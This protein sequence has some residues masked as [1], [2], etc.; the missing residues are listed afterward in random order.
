MY[1]KQLTLQGYKS[2]ASRTEFLFSKGITAV[3]G[4]NG[5]GKSNIADAIRWALGEQ[6]LRVLRGKSTH[7]MIFAGGRRRAQSGM[8]EAS[9]TLDNTD[10]GLPIDFTEVTI[11]RRAYRSGENEYLVNGSRV[12]LR[13]VTQLLAESGLSQRAYAVI[14]QGLVDAALSLRPQERR[15][16][17]EEAAGTAFYRSQLE[18]AVRRLDETQRN[19]ER[20]RDIV[21]EITPRLH[22]LERE[23]E[24]VEE[25][26]RLTTHLRRLQRTW[27][28]YQWGRLQADL[29]HAVERADALQASLRARQEHLV[30]LE[31]RISQ[32]R[33]QESELR[34]SLRDWH[35]QSSDLHS[36]AE[37]VQRELAVAEERSRLLQTRHEELAG[38]LERLRDQEQAQEAHVAQVQAEA[39]RLK[40]DLAERKSRLVELEQRWAALEARAR[41][42]AQRQAEVEDQLRARQAEM[43]TLNRMLVEVRA[44]ATHLTGEQVL[45]E[46]RVRQLASQEDELV[47][48]LVSLDEQQQRQAEK[49]AQAERQVDQQRRELAASQQRFRDLE[50]QW[51]TARAEAQRPPPERARLEN[52]ILARRAHSDSLNQ[53]LVEARAKEA[54]LA[55]QLE[56]LEQMQAGADA[57]S[58]G[59]QALLSA[60]L[61]GVHGPL[62]TLMTVPPEWERA[63]EAALGRDLQAVVVDH[64][65]LVEK[66]R[67]VVDAV[68]GR[69]VL[70][71]LDHLR[72]PPPLPVGVLRAADVVSFVDAAR[73]AVEALLGGTVL[74][75][76][77]ETARS[78]LPDLPPGSQGVTVQGTVLR[79]NGAL[80][81]GQVEL[82]GVLKGERARRELPARLEAARRHRQEIERQ[83][84]AEAANIA[85]LEAELRALDRRLAEA[86][87]DAANRE[88]EAMAKARAELAGAE[89]AT[90]NLEAALQREA[91]LL[92][93]LQA[94]A[95]SLQQQAGELKAERTSL[96]ARLGE[97][98][99]RER[100]AEA[101]QLEMTQQ[102]TAVP[103]HAAHV[104][105][106][107]E[108]QPP[109]AA[110]TRLRSIESREHR[111]EAQQR[112]AA[113]TAAELE[114]T[115]AEL[116]QE[117]AQ[118]REMA[119]Q[120]ER[121]TLAT[122]RTEVAVAEEAL[123]NWQA[124]LQRETGLLDR[125]R[126]QVS[127]RAYRVKELEVEREALLSKVKDLHAQAS[128]MEGQLSRL[129]ERIQPAEEE[130][131]RVRADLEALADQVRQAQARVRDTELR[132]GQAKLEAE[133]RQDKLRL[134]AQQI[135]EELGLV[136]LELT[137][138]VTAQTP[139]PLRPLVSVLPVVEDLPQGLEEE[140]HRL[141]TRLHRLRGVNP[142]APAEY[143]ETKERHQFLVEQS[144]DL[145]KA[146]AQLRQTATELD[147]LMKAAFQET[148]DAVAAEFSRIFTVLF[149]GGRARLELTD[150]DDM[151]NTGVDIVAQPP[152]KRAQRLALLSSGERALTATALL[153]SLLRVSPTPFC[154][155]DEVDAM[156][157]EANVGRFRGLLEE[158]AQQTQFVVITH[159]RVTVEAADTIYGVSMGADGVSQVVSLKLD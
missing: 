124:A 145:E 121:E 3:V 34:T 102:E 150:P 74:C 53:A 40:A 26:R 126:A 9:L 155:L 139:L 115:L 94:Q 82:D 62:S 135:E 48:R 98:R 100:H 99:A 107:D 92:E 73:P 88:R 127:A 137:D 57:C 7:D 17:F 46:E 61:E 93:Q 75:D 29:S 4:P 76:D 157:D 151:M 63:I 134:L 113:R 122:A 54:Q 38:E 1:L 16:L 156:L 85:T 149:N 42:T 21:N 154:V 10:G 24:R 18:D 119:A 12:R 117:T 101:S 43:D 31:E 120:F 84:R 58:V 146:T 68:G 147:G 159:N 35:G 132:R 66:V 87:E 81:V 78:L 44:E 67:Q 110:F 83:Q 153:F 86:R 32:L 128:E 106:E 65:S 14:G 105:L 133:R 148:F 22:R 11:A 131:G 104:D 112:A 158:M 144:V 77:L 80:L 36:K 138:S 59:L 142:N 25:H 37:D 95:A 123:R 143:E 90:Y 50:Q 55:G 136:E 6:S 130:L 129:Q 96:A 72:Q 13:D 47:A 39:E 109:D 28:G 51:A 114:A 118:A 89:R 45:T 60:N 52:E 2:F 79:A 69:L 5:S 33:Q 64:L 20:V 116:S 15:T 41:E 125:L 97:W 141:K 56:A 108:E 19:L 23:V 71:P 111:I 70:L 140:I 49:V 27:Y 103:D 8:A 152:G 30:A 91:I